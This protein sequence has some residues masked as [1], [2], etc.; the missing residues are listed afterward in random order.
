MAG[1]VGVDVYG[2]RELRTSMKRMGVEGSGKALREAHKNVSKFVEGRARGRGTRQQVSASRALLGKGTQKNA[3]LAIRN[4]A[5]VPFGIGA[6]M[7]AEGQFGWYGRS[8]YNSST[9]KQ[10]PE[11]VG[12]NWRL[13]DGIGPY[14]IADVIKEG[15]AD[16]LE[17][18][19]DEMR[20]AAERLGLEFE[21]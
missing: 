1:R 2:A 16:I 15:H 3:V 9:G 13:E 19:L 6:F 5:S 18:F 21:Y 8:R 20:S 10:F 4:L 11:W 14:V 7:G 17:A 12:N